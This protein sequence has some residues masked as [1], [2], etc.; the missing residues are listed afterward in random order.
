MKEISMKN[1][2]VK[3]TTTLKRDKNQIRGGEALVNLQ[4]RIHKHK[5]NKKNIYISYV[6]QILG[7][8]KPEQNDGWERLRRLTMRQPAGG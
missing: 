1:I 7:V 5:N 3:Q 6:Y 4:M 2:G 8:H